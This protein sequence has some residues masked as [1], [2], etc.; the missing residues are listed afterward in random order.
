MTGMAEASAKTVQLHVT[1]TRHDE[2]SIVLEYRVTN[3]GSEPIYLLDRPARDVHG[4]GMVVMDQFAHVMF[5]EPDVV[6]VV[7]GILP[8]P[9]DHNVARRA[10]TFLTKVEPGQTVARSLELPVPLREQRSY[11]A[12]DEEP[13]GIKRKVSK[14]RFELA[15]TEPRP[16]MQIRERKLDSGPEMVLDGRWD[17]PYQRVLVATIPIAPTE[18]ELHSEPFDR[19]TLVQ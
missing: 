18:L 17:P 13:S 19:A 5:A 14:V 7:R 11:Y 9:R 15:Y 2:R 4:G 6:R 3:N 16:G 10:P 12:D 8:L 1:E